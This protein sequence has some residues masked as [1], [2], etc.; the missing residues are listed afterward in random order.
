MFLDSVPVDGGQSK[1]VA[2]ILGRDYVVP[3]FD[4]ELEGLKKGETKEFSLMFPNE[5]H[6]KNGCYRVCHST[7]RD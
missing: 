5:H 4:K 7:E 6:Q 1:G 3:G 2:V